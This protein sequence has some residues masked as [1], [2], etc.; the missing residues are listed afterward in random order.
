V[1]ETDEPAP[2]EAREISVGINGLAH[3]ACR[4]NVVAV[5]FRPIGTGAY[6]EDLACAG[7]GASLTVEG[8]L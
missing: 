3:C 4:G 8:L 6:A 7:C 1:D 5:S 2:G